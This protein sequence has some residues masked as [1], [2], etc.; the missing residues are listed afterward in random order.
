MA[1]IKGKKKKYKRK[2]NGK[3]DTWNK[4]KFDMVVVNQLVRMFNIACTITQACAYARISTVTYY[5]RVK[6]NQ[7]LPYE[8]E[9]PDT[10]KKVV[11]NTRF[12]DIVTMAKEFPFILAKGTVFKWM[13]K[14]DTRLAMDFLKRREPW[15]SDKIENTNF[16]KDVPVTVIEMDL[17]KAIAK[18]TSKSRK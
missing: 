1:A 10:H 17:I 11:I 5:E 8:L 14:W 13:Q 4:G 16:N 18:E 2:P 3:N 6:E 15:W 9:D 12:N 7:L